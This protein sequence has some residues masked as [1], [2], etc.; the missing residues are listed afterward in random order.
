MPLLVLLIFA[1]GLRCPRVLSL[2]LI[3]LIARCS[4]IGLPIGQ[5]MI[6]SSSRSPFFQ[7]Q[8]GSARGTQ[9][10][11]RTWRHVGHVSKGGGGPAGAAVGLGVEGAVELRLAAAAAVPMAA[12][13][14]GRGDAEA[15]QGLGAQGY[16]HGGARAVG[17]AATHRA[18]RGTPE[19]VAATPD[20]VLGR[21]RA[22]AAAVHVRRG[23]TRAARRPLL[24]AA[25][26][27]R[28]RRS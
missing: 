16:G 11:Q 10:R 17:G 13:G 12:L 24:L 8:D 20:D 26:K 7:P 21:V 27:P 9:G 18:A 4:P 6:R 25:D 14:V 3:R 1:N 22:P 5:E 15:G 23:R 2:P 28:D 19:G